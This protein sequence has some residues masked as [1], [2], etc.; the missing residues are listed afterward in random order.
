MTLSPAT[1]RKKS[2]ALDEYVDLKQ[3]EVADWGPP[4]ALRALD[5]NNHALVEKLRRVR[6]AKVY[7]RSAFPERWHYQDSPRVFPVLLL[8]DEGWTI[9]SKEYF[10][11][12]PDWKQGGNHGYDNDL[13]SMRALFIAA[14]PSFSS[15]TTMK[16]F[17]NVHLYS[18]MAYLLNLRPAAT[19]G[20]INVF[21]DVLVTRGETAPPHP[22]R[23]PWRKERDEMALATQK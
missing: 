12:H 17:S 7:Q 21:K 11:K 23:A 22:E 10:D 6:H 5:G 8:A 4:V 20:S 15:H 13:K 19:D 16:P 1:S 9:N 18:L 2:I 14:G 3:L